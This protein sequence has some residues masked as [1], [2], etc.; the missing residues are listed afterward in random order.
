M[1]IETAD[2]QKL[3]AALNRKLSMPIRLKDIELDELLFR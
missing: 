2:T 1:N 3:Q